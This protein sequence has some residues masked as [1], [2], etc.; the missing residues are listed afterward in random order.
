MDLLPPALRAV[1]TRFP[2]GS[3]EQK[4]DQALVLIK[5]FFPVGR[6]TFY[7]T[8]GRAED[9]DFLF[10]G[11]GI[12]PFGPDCDEW[13]YTTLSELLSVQHRGLTIERDLHFPIAE[14]TVKDVL[15]RAA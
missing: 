9:D 13:G 11:Y 5:Y 8:E 7:V 6:Y 10:F 12:S 2:I 14:R 4:G 1:L 3:Q 15:S